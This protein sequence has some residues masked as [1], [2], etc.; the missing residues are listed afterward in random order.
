LSGNGWGEVMAAYKLA[1]KLGEETD[2]SGA[3]LLEYR[4]SGG[5]WGDVHHARLSTAT[6]QTTDALLAMHAD[7]MNWGQI[8]KELGLSGPP[9]DRGGD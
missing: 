1:D 4:E 5:S 2:F 6:G 7:G 3:D 8:R 9:E